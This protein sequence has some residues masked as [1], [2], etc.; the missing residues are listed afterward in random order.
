MEAKP[1]EDYDSEK[2]LLIMLYLSHLKNKAEWAT[3]DK[4]LPQID[5]TCHSSRCPLAMH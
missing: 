2:L 4:V 1:R 3:F 5:G